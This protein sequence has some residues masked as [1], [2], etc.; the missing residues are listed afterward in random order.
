MDESIE[1]GIKQNIIGQN[2]IEHD[3]EE[4]FKQLKSLRTENLDLRKKIMY[5][6]YLFLRLVNGEIYDS[7]NYYISVLE[8]ELKKIKESSDYYNEI[9]RTIMDKTFRHNLIEEFKDMTKDEKFKVMNNNNDYDKIILFNKLLLYLPFNILFFLKTNK[10][11]NSI[12][13]TTYIDLKLS[14]FDHYVRGNYYIILNKFLLNYKQMKKDSEIFTKFYHNNESKK[15]NERNVYAKKGF[16]VFTGKIEM[17]GNCLFRSLCKF[18]NKEDNHIDLRKLISDNI[19]KE[20]FFEKETVTNT[21]DGGNMR[22]NETYKEYMAKD[23]NW[24]GEPELRI[25]SAIFKCKI[26]LIHRDKINKN[27]VSDTGIIIDESKNEKF[28]DFNNFNEFKLKDN[29]KQAETVLLKYTGYH[30]EPILMVKNKENKI[31]FNHDNTP[32]TPPNDNFTKYINEGK[33]KSFVNNTNVKPYSDEYL[34]NDDYGL[35]T[36]KK[37]NSQELLYVIAEDKKSK[38]IYDYYKELFIKS[39]EVNPVILIPSGDYNDEVIKNQDVEDIK[40]IMIQIFIELNGE[41]GKDGIGINIEKILGN[42]KQLIRNIYKTETSGRT[43]SNAVATAVVDDNRGSGDY[44]SADDEE[45]S[46]ELDNAGK[47]GESERGS[48]GGRGR[49]EA[50]HHNVGVGM[51]TNNRRE[52]T[53]TELIEL[54]TKLEEEMRR[55]N[56]PFL[57]RNKFKKSRR[58]WGNTIKKSVHNGYQKLQNL[59]GKTKKKK[60]TIRPNKIINQ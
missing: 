22:I 4:V 53:T 39:F 6:T 59:R 19:L 33:F 45:S 18:L 48:G 50:T 13:T 11:E 54:Q 26:E 28:E 12:I 49:P 43:R 2:I 55:L 37:R 46:V 25:F 41:S 14:D 24:G 3:V 27:T 57:A 32:Y 47:E 40:K 51:S 56:K 1:T 42:H 21:K 60:K 8:N 38:N 17:D 15:S 29:V 36:L 58:T 35:T 44:M 23:G 31:I 9:A 52:G 10:K 20:G 30:Y 16:E 34:P 5:A 7:S